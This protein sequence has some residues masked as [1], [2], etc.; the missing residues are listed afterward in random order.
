MSAAQT[1][2]ALQS[3]TAPLGTIDFKK[4]DL[5]A[6][7]LASWNARQKALAEIEAVA[8]FYKADEAAP[9]KV[10]VFDMLENSIPKMPARTAKGLMA[11]LWLALAHSGPVCSTDELR[12]ES[13]AIRRA[14]FGEVMA[15]A[16]RLDF[17]QQIIFHAI[18]D[19]R[20]FLK[21]ERGAA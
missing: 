5:D 1:I 18:R 16:D 3:A 14:D 12:A 9:A 20:Q 8:S 15:F 21:L 19:I 6:P 13:D 17:D 11:K 2:A 10:A 7:L 4:G